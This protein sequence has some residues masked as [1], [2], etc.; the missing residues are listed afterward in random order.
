MENPLEIMGN[1]GKMWE[2]P[3]D[4]SLP[5]WRSRLPLAKLLW[6]C[7]AARCTRAWSA[8][9]TIPKFPGHWHVKYVITGHNISQKLSMFISLVTLVLSEV[10]YVTCFSV[11]KNSS[12]EKHRPTSQK[13]RSS[14]SRWPPP[15]QGTALWSWNGRC[16]CRNNVEGVTP[17]KWQKPKT[18]KIF[19]EKSC[20]VGISKCGN[21]V[22]QN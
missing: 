5:P 18:G 3:Q 4:V 9:G 21:N 1:H 15:N 16:T 11:Q 13:V 2:N 8:G 6:Y 10:I 20:G 7:A 19:W 14:T 22:D 17:K 12:C